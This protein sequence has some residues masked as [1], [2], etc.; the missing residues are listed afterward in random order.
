[1]GGKM[2]STTYLAL[3]QIGYNSEIEKVLAG[4][5]DAV[6]F[7]AS[8]TTASTIMT[9]FQTIDSLHVPFVGSD[10]ESASDW[11]KAVTPQVA[12]AHVISV[13]PGSESDAAA[14][15]QLNASYQ[16]LY[17]QAPVSGAN[18]NF[19]AVIDLALAI[20]E[21]GGTSAKQI[22]AGLAAVSDPPGRAVGTY[23][24]GVQ[25]LK[26]HIKINYRGA[27]GP[28]AFNAHHSISSPWQIVRSSPS[29]SSLQVIGTISA[30]E[31][32]EARG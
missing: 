26:Q 14:V 2:V 27:S 12:H 20:D 3:G 21:A 31:I 4:H 23:A 16:A 1:L 17:H 6:F 32:E 15:A 11:I 8:P 5:P 10:V 24:E 25:L 19:D 30:K 13:Q 22:E 9:E 18:S 29:G 7:D 28:M